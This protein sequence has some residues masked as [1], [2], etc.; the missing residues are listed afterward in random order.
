MDLTIAWQSLRAAASTANQFWHAIPAEF[1]VALYALWITAAVI[2]ILLQRRPP[3]TTLAWTIAFMTLPFVGALVYAAFGPRRLLRRRMR[4]TLAKDLAANL[5]PGALTEFPEK[6]AD[7]HW[8]AALA[9]VASSAGDGPPRPSQ[10]VRLFGDGDSTYAAIEAAVAKAREQIHIEYYIYEPDAVGVRLRDALVVRARAGVA[11]R[12]LV[13]ALG[14][15][16]A[17]TRFW[18]PL[19]DAGGEVRYFNPLRLLRLQPG[20]LNFRTHRKIVVIDGLH[21]FT[22]GINVSAGNSALSSGGSAWRDTHIEFVGAPAMD[23][24]LVFLEDWLF[25]GTANNISVGRDRALIQAPTDIQRWF[26]APPAADGPWVQII[27]SGPDEPTPDIH[28][29]F[30]TAMASAR[31]RLWITTPYFVPDE[32]IIT[33]LVTAAARGVDVRIIVPRQGDSR[34]VTAAAST[35]ADEVAAE[36]VKVYEYQPRMI[37]AKT[38]VVDDELAIVGTANMDNRSFRLNF[39]VIAAIYDREVAAELAMM[40]ESDLKL[41]APVRPET[42]SR[43]FVPRVLASAARLFAPLL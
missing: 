22:G 14:S 26:P 23:L 27:D 12:V 42:R 17:G 13:D 7:R 9:R 30:F 6:L 18:Q 19:C 25:A 38:I 8:L 2:F 33:A 40:F 34:L 21:A 32:P 37:H 39:E 36:G 28:R 31:R 11:V 5:V 16:N 41:T 43:G 24:Q 10:R 3:T 4:R 20:T 29:F 15:K 35:F 1:W